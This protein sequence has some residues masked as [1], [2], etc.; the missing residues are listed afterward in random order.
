M[1]NTLQYIDGIDQVKLIDGVIRFDL[2]GIKEINDGK[3][4]PESL[5]GLAM[6]LQA[7]LRMHEQMS[8][9]TAKMID[10][11]ILKKNSPVEIPTATNLNDAPVKKKTPQSTVNLDKN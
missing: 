10:Q 8:K 6:S 7:F 4:E 1:K 5:G 11:G 2:V 9:V 3:I